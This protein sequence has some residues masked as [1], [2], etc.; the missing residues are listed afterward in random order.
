M[1]NASLWAGI[2]GPLVFWI[3]LF[4]CGMAWENYSHL[5][6]MVS[7]L[8][9]DGT[10]TQYFFT[11]GLVLSSV[12]NLFFS[13]QIIRT[14]RLIQISTI[15]AYFLIFYSFLAGPGI[16]S[17]P[18]HLH[19]FAG[20]PFYLIMLCP[21]MGLVFWRKADNVLKFRTSAIISIAFIIFSFGIFFPDVFPTFFGLKQRFLYISFSVWSMYLAYRFLSLES[22]SAKEGNPVIVR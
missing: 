22:G 20:A 16:F 13:L 7:A 3:T 1:K 19:Q 17:Y 6:Q 2:A 21:V 15:P 11:T 18:H 9:M 10:N 4:G 14:S 8:G 12:L 5:S